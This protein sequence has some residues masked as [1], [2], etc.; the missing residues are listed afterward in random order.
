MTDIPPGGVT[1]LF[2]AHTRTVHVTLAVIGLYDTTMRCLD[3]G[4]QNTVC[5][6][7]GDVHRRKESWGR[8][9]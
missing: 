9:L 3:V 1:G 8:T 2:R 4:D 5:H 6:Y 7:G